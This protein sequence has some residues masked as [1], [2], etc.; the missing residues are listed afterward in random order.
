M[1]KFDIYQ[2][3]A[4][5]LFLCCTV[6]IGT[7][8]CSVIK[9]VNTQR[10]ETINKQHTQKSIQLF[11]KIKA[12]VDNNQATAT[13]LY[14]FAHMLDSGTFRS[15]VG[16]AELTVN[17]REEIYANYLQQAIKKGSQEAKLDY[18]Y[19]LYRQN[20]N[21]TD[22]NVDDKEK[23]E[24]L[25]NL[26][27]SLNLIE[28]VFNTQCSVYE[29][30]YDHKFFAYPENKVSVRS[31]SYLVWANDQKIRSDYPELYQQAKKI[32][33]TYQKNCIKNKSTKK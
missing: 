31:R 23:N 30:P 14:L 1:K 16:M 22:E 8:A 15:A 5:L 32:E 2:Y 17:E 19:L 7:G 13:D 18:A 21:I 33:K 25:L 28:A 11:K 24:K 12:R 4:T 29:K 26:K 3:K 20:G 27:Q 9:S 6:L 10:Y